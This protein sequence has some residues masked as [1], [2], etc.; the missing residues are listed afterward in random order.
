MITERNNIACRLIMK[1]TEAG[2]LGGRFVQM[3]IGRE[4]HLALPNL[5]IP[6]GST[7]RTVPEWLFPHR[8]PTKHSLR[9]ASCLLIKQIIN[10]ISTLGMH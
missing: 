7:N 2:S 4:D 6:V 10:Q 8:F 1:A 5:Q 3:D 9:M